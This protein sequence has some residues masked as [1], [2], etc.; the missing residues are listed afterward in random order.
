MPE[1]FMSLILFS[2]IT[3]VVIVAVMANRLTANRYPFPFDR[4]ATVFTAAE[5]N[6]QSLLEQAVGSNFR[7]LNRVK[8]ADLI[9][10]RHGVSTKASQTALNNANHKYV[11]F[12]L[13]HRDSMQLAGA[14]DLVDTNGKGYK[15]K[16]D[17]FVSGAL[18]AANIPHLR[19]KVKGSYT[20]NEIRTCINNR[21]LGVPVAEPKFKGR[22][23]P[24][25]L[26]KARSKNTGVIP[27]A[28]AARTKQK[29]NPLAAKLQAQQLTAMHH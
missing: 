8:I 3:L 9:T 4:K 12:V 19:I 11:D 28:S 21:I 17:W 26:V 29:P 27:S 18:E 22:V 23:L 6:F 1:M 10:V 7:V 2:L 25:P 20:L 16:K 15:V 14:I 13:C 24:A 5:K